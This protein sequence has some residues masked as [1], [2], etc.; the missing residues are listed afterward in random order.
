MGP[1]RFIYDVKKNGFD[2]LRSGTLDLTAGTATIEIVVYEPSMIYVQVD[3]G[4]RATPTCGRC[5]AEAVC[6]RRSGGRSRPDAAIGSPTGGFRRLLGRQAESA[7]S[8]PDERGR[9][10]DRV[11]RSGR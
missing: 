9:D 8:T 7:A 10:T 1:S 4:G 5:A 6:Q 11:E 3:T 2:V